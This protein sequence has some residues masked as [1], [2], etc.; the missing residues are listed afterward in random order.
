[1]STGRSDSSS[2]ARVLRFASRGLTH[3][4]HGHGHLTQADATLAN[5]QGRTA[6]HLACDRGRATV[7]APLAA[8]GADADA[9]DSLGAAPGGTQTSPSRCFV[10]SVPRARNRPRRTPSSAQRAAGQESSAANAVRGPSGRFPRRRRPAGAR[11]GERPR[12]LRRRSLT[13]RRE[14]VVGRRRRHRRREALRAAQTSRRRFKRRARR[15]D[16]RRGRGRGLGQS[17]P[18]GNPAGRAAQV[19]RRLARELPRGRLRRGRRKERFRVTPLLRRR[20]LGGRGAMVRVRGGRGPRGPRSREAHAF[21][22]V[23]GPRRQAARPHAPGDGPLRRRRHGRGRTDRVRTSGGGGRAA[24][25]GP[26]QASYGER[27]RGAPT[28]ARRGPAASGPRRRESSFV[29][30]RGRARRQAHGVDAR[31][32][33]SRRGRA[34]R[35]SRCVRTHA[36]RGVAG[37]VVRFENLTGRAGSGGRLGPEEHEPAPEVRDERGQGGL[38]T[39]RRA[40]PHGALLRRRGGPRGERRVATERVRRAKMLPSFLRE[41]AATCRR[42][43]AGRRVDRPRTRR[44]AAGCRVDRPPPAAQRAYRR[45]SRHPQAW[46]GARRRRAARARCST[47]TRRT[48]TATRL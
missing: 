26:G 32:K 15:S 42:T 46:A 47:W 36:C 21:D 41:D 44:N 25:D 14:G 24:P 35:R 12:R 22:G 48:G 33:K 7:V 34:A 31:E 20:Q 2:R 30:S 13:N 5:A 29:R 45:R 39:A 43:A 23:R 1:M 18:V 37:S 4:V 11:R 6:L 38:T 27:R 3:S 9:R 19:R 28:S 40:G 10:R 17:R 8:A 16:V